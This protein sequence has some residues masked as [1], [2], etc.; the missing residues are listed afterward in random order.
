MKMPIEHSRREFL[1][2]SLKTLA[3]VALYGLR[4]A[5]IAA[6]EL[7]LTPWV[8]VTS[9]SS[10]PLKAPTIIKRDWAKGGRQIYDTIHTNINNINSAFAEIHRHFLDLKAVFNIDLI[11]GQV[12]AESMIDA[13]PALERR[14]PEIR[15][16]Q[17]ATRPLTELR[18]FLT[19]QFPIGDPTSID[20]LSFLHED[21]I[22]TI[23]PSHPTG[24][25]SFEMRISRFRNKYKLFDAQFYGTLMSP[26]SLYIVNPLEI[27]EPEEGATSQNL[28]VRGPN[29]MGD[30]SKFDVVEMP[31]TKEVR[32]SLFKDP[33]V[34]SLS[35]VPPFPG[36]L[37]AY[38]EGVARLADNLGRALALPRS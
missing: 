27:D 16:D 21:K 8:S 12:R 30:D 3:G 22:I 33:P 17:I 29:L 10:D 38:Y 18:T 31:Y 7:P 37:V 11:N 26:E 24:S 13:I 9:Y 6:E 20:G 25:H 1:S 14:I 19:Q 36:I 34:P 15:W 4:A 5:R 35:F 2:F 23:Y 28:S 32:D